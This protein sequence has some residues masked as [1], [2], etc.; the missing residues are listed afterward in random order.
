MLN[1]RKIILV[2]L[3]NNDGSTTDMTI[4][5]HFDEAVF[6]RE[7]ISGMCG[8]LMK[9]KDDETKVF[10]LENQIRLIV[11]AEDVNSEQA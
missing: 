2:R 8:L 7:E 9:Y 1:D 6:Y 5:E 4:E 10:L 11:T 3:T